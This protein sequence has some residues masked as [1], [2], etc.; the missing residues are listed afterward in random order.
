[1][2]PIDTSY[3]P[4]LPIPFSV[5]VALSEVIIQRYKHRRR[6]HHQY[7]D[8]TASWILSVFVHIMITYAYIAIMALPFM[9]ALIQRKVRCPD[10][11]QPPVVSEDAPSINAVWVFCLKL[12]P[13]HKYGICQATTVQQ[14]A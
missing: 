9:L 2:T 13:L 3:Q 8:H 7:V 6:Q 11:L 10:Q 12:R 5:H 4:R 14:P 1:M